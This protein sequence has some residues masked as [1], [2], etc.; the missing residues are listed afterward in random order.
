[1]SRRVHELEEQL[2]QL[3]WRKLQNARRINEILGNIKRQQ[4][5]DSKASAES[6]AAASSEYSKWLKQIEE[7]ENSKPLRLPWDTI[8]RLR[9]E[10]AAQKERARK[11]Q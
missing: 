9:E 2:A 1:M 7:D 10:R 6:S 3:E 4:Q 5:E 11:V 8:K